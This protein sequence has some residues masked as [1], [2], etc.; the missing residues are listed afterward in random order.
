MN[1]IAR[2]PR[3]AFA[4]LA[5]VLPLLWQAA[6]ASAA[7]LGG[8][9]PLALS[10]AKVTAASGAPAVV[11]WENFDGANGA[12]LNGTTLDGGGLTWAAPRCTWTIQTNQARSTSGD[13]PLVVNPAIWNYSAEVVVARN[14]AS[15]F[16]A[17]CFFNSNAAAT[18]FMSVEY[19][20]GS[21]GSVEL[22]SFNGGWTFLGSVTN[23]YSGGIGTAPATVTLRVQTT[24]T[25]VIISLNGVAV[26]TYTLNAAQIATYKN[27]THTRAGLY[28][29]FDAVST[30]NDF[31]LDNP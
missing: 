1:A 11:A 18:Q 31:H 28:T 13:C 14:G 12:N 17:G 10:A 24:A 25:Q 23:L 27:A 19:T 20:S 26:L 8:I 29:Y 9:V 16:D 6:G 4:V 22:W 21:N 5:G 7:S 2:R 30:F 3:L 15:A